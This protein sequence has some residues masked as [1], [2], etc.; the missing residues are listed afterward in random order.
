MPAKEVIIPYSDA[1]F[2]QAAI[3]WLVAT[4]QPVDAFEDPRFVNMI[5]IASCTKNGV[6]IPGKKGLGQRSRTCS[7]SEWIL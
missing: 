7:S 6:S 1:L 5:N 3:E 2:R 4:D